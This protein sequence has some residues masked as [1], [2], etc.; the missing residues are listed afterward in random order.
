M[1]AITVVITTHLFINVGFKNYACYE[2]YLQSNDHIPRVLHGVIWVQN[3]AF[4]MFQDG[5]VDDNFLKF[6]KKVYFCFTSL[7]LNLLRFLCC[8]FKHD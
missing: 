2:C 1:G 4:R 8:R 6:F 3:K 5:L 7:F